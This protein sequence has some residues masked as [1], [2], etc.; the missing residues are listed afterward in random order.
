MYWRSSKRQN[1]CDWK[2]PAGCDISVFTIRRGGRRV[3]FDY[4]IPRFFPICTWYLYN[5][6][7]VLFQRSYAIKME[8]KTINPFCGGLTK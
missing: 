4:I 6:L 1:L 8:P 5:T 7:N 2:R 3:Y